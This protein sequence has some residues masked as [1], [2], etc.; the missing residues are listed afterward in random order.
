M[1]WKLPEN[2]KSG[3]TNLKDEVV[4]GSKLKRVDFLGAFSLVGTI[5]T[6]LL[7]LDQGTK[8]LAWYYLVPICIMFVL[9]ASMFIIVE[10]RF[11]KEPV[12]PLD[13]I[14]KRDVYTPYLIIGLQAAGQFGVSNIK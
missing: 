7:A 2:N 4:G 5:M 8:G 3:D 10:K 6:C 9:F 12:L 1:L 14:S 11:A 13:L